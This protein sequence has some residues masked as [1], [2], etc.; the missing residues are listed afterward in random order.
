MI[1]PTTHPDAALTAAIAAFTAVLGPPV[2]YSD[3]YPRWVWGEHRG[4]HAINGIHVQHSWR[5]GGAM[6]SIVRNADPW[7][8]LTFWPDESAPELTVAEVLDR[9]HHIMGIR[10]VP[11]RSLTAAAK[12]FLDGNRD[13]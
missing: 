3:T 4:P 11:L 6:V 9:E 5:N 7:C 8:E 1:I 12:W 2:E 10:K 13:W